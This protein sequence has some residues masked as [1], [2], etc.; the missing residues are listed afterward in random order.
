MAPIK[1]EPDGEHPASHY[2]VVDNPQLVTTWHM[3]YKN[4]DGT[5]NHRY[6]GAAWAA[7]HGGYRGNKYEG[8][9]KRDA[10]AKLTKLYEGEKMMTPTERMNS[11]IRQKAGR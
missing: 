7:L 10:I 6:M 11:E 4:P 8:P 5:I 9:A 1:K 3:L 2:L